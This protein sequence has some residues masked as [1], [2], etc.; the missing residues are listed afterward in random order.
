MMAG[1]DDTGSG[2]AE[3]HPFVSRGVDTIEGCTVFYMY[4]YVEE[5]LD[6]PGYSGFASVGA[7]LALG[8]GASH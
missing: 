5:I 7:K 4:M 8:G 3:K 1:I 6:L 2:M